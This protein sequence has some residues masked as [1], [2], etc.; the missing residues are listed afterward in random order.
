[1][2]R[3]WDKGA[4]V[5]D[6]ILRFTVGSDYVFDNR[7]VEYDVRASIAH[8]MMLR[9]KGYLTA[10]EFRQIETGLIA[11]GEQH[12]NGGWKISLE[13]EDAHTAIENRLVKEI[14]D[15]GKKV[16]LARSRNDQVLA[17][18]RL[19]LM[20]EIE[21]VSGAAKKVIEALEIIVKEQGDVVLPGF[22]HMQ[23][24]MPSSVSLWAGGFVRELR[25][26]VDGLRRTRSRV[27]VNPLGSV[28]GY[29]AGPLDID[30]EATARSLGFDSVQ[31]PVT[32]VQL[33][34]GKAEASVI[35]ELVL[36]VND[37]GRLAAD[38][39]LF[40]TSEF[41]YVH[42]ADSITT[43]SSVMP[44]K[45]NPDVFELVRARSAQIPAWLAESLNICNKMTSGYH[46]DMQLLKEPLLRSI[47]VA[48]SVCDIMAHA[49]NE[50]RFTPESIRVDK[51][52][53]A[54][55]LAYEMVVRDNISFRDAYRI[56]AESKPW[57]GSVK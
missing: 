49:L 45:R 7:L 29:G 28:A 9:D 32:S 50:I 22:T 44:Q 40:S 1:M 31:S 54:A 33:S 55:E 20:N 16:H 52:I 35:F 5:D 51:S 37:L 47:D 24:A 23:Q 53:F 56:I 21:V 13:E 17:A 36:L 2:K 12:A 8:A 30:R 10:E 26:D 6:M 46:R 42:L 38:L 41:S 11:I 3:L 43:G 48:T 4:A 14:G 19:Y 27:N 34:R 15:V 57:E 18:L 39:V 25:D